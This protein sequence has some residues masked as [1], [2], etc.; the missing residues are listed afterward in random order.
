MVRGENGGAATPHVAE[1]GLGR[2]QLAP[3][4][5]DS[6]QLVKRVQGLAMFW[7]TYPRGVFVIATN[8]PL[9]R[10]E[11][12]ERM[13]GESLSD[14]RPENQLMI[15]AESALRPGQH[16][17]TD[18]PRR[19]E[20]TE[21]TQHESH[22]DLGFEPRRLVLWSCYTQR[23]P[24]F[25]GTNVNW[26]FS[27]ACGTHKI[28]SST[29]RNNLVISDNA[30]VV[31]NYFRD[32]IP[33]EVVIRTNSAGASITASVADGSGQKKRARSRSLAPGA[34]EPTTAF[35]CLLD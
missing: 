3:T 23:L 19:L 26:S 11:L 18:G 34:A 7:P 14:L 4:L 32:T 33:R 31:A 20:L 24:C 13:A 22:L 30:P 21:G 8:P 17:F 15:R 5:Q 16:P 28:G 2:D 12:T 35:L 10:I 25:S 29:Q 9:R 6:C 27:G 1:Q